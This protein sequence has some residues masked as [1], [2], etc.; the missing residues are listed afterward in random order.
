MAKQINPCPKCKKKLGWYEK[1]V[2]SYEQYYDADCKP[3]HAA[4]RNT[5]GGNQK[6]CFDCGKKITLHIAA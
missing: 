1:H 6:F 3:S 4:D 5:R 2:T